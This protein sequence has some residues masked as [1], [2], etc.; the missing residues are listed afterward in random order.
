[1]EANLLSFISKQ[2][3]ITQNKLKLAK[4]TMRRFLICC[5]VMEADLDLATTISEYFL[6]IVEY[7][8][9]DYL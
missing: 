3:I 1:M 9:L 2:I 4:I 8:E 5:M 6:K 7:V